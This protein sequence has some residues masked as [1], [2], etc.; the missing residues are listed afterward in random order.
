[1]AYKYMII[2]IGL[3]GDSME[4]SEDPGK[5]AGIREPGDYSK[6]YKVIK[7]G[8]QPNGIWLGF[9]DDEAAIEKW[10]KSDRG[11]RFLKMVQDIIQIK[12]KKNY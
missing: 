4:S 9:F 2:G 6:G 12:L 3:V 8:W 5:S 10:E 1:M 11:Q 7:G